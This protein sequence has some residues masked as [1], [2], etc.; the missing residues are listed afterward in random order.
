VRSDAAA[1]FGAVEFAEDMERG[2]EADEAEAHH[3]NHRRRNLQPRSIVC[4]EPQHVAASTAA[5]TGAGAVSTGKTA[6]AHAG[7]GS[8][9]TAGS[10]DSWSRGR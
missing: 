3:Q 8:S 9:R 10:R 7:G 2:D 1:S 4:V 6:T 5:D